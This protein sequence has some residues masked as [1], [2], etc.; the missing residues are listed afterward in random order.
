MTLYEQ[1]AG[2]EPDPHTATATSH[3]ITEDGDEG[4]GF[5]RKALSGKIRPAPREPEITHY[6]CTDR[7]CR[8]WSA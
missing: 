6:S 8:S 2:R 3:K 7:C 1:G 4:D 5:F